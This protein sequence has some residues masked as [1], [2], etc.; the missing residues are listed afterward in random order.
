MKKRVRVLY[1]Q[2]FDADFPFPF[3]TKLLDAIATLQ[4][5]AESIPEEF[6]SS[7]SLRVDSEIEYDMNKV[8]IEIYYD[9]PETNEEVAER[10]KVEGDE[11]HRREQGELAQLAALKAKYER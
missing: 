6:R 9:R 5:I 2:E 3:G 7:A 4:R 11:T 1:T 10:K 8:L